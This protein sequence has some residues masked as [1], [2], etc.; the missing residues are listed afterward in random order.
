MWLLPPARRNPLGVRHA[1]GPVRPGGQCH[2]CQPRA[3][4][5]GGRG[6]PSGGSGW[7]LPAA[8]GTDHT[9]RCALIYSR[10]PNANAGSL[11]VQEAVQRKRAMEA[12]LQRL[13]AM[14]AKNA[15]RQRQL[16]QAKAEQQAKAQA[17][18][19]RSFRVKPWEWPEDPTRLCSKRW[20]ASA[21]PW[22]TVAVPTVVARSAYQ[23]CGWPCYL[24][25]THGVSDCGA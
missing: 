5:P 25:G 16:E 17:R 8:H 13:Q 2:P 6:A 15:E 19:R 21:A 3:P 4:A 7:I 23:M 9:G 11:D 18:V 1:P 20:L 12:K 24:A 10:R 14:R 22:H